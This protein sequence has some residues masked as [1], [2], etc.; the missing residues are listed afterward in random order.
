MNYILYYSVS[1]KHAS[2]EQSLVAPTISELIVDTRNAGNKS[3][4]K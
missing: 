4:Y 3:K 2:I 1:F